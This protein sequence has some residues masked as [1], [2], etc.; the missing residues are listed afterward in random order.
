[1]TLSAETSR[2]VHALIASRLGLDVSERRQAELA[3]SLRLPCPGSPAEAPDAYVARLAAL[4]DHSPAW[5]RLVSRLTVG[6]TYFFRNGAAFDALEREVLPALIATRRSAGIHRLRLWSAGCATG[7]EPFS[8]AMLLDRLL[9]DRAEWAITILATDIN[10][11]ALDVARRGCYRAWS[12]RETPAW[13]R[14]RYFRPRP[15]NT[16][17]VEP[18]IRQMVVFAPL[19]LAEDSYPAPVTNTTAMDLLLC[20]NVLMYFT[21]EAQRRASA[22][23]VRALAPDGWLV[24]SPAEASV[25]RFRPLVP[26]NFPGATFYRQ[27]RK[28]AGAPSPAP[29]PAPVDLWAP[30]AGPGPAE[31]PPGPDLPP[32][33]TPVRD[34]SRR[35]ASIADARAL[36]DQGRLEEAQRLCEAMIARDRL[37]PEPYL[38][39]AAIHQERDDVP[40]ALKV[41]RQAV[42]L[43]PD[44][45]TAHLLRGALLRRC[46]DKRREARRALETAVRL[47]GRLPPDAPVDGAGGVTARRLLGTARAYLELR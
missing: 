14:E 38:L 12:L 8:L 44:A 40:A 10:V 37:D 23:L 33:P 36:A 3:Q 45:A 20:R 46:K 5:R 18:R 21:P 22:R 17:E 47:L 26:V 9:P 34:A 4:P 28:A 13:A 29:P 7:E 16:F 1:M 42:Y 15:G 43:A 27:D 30:G 31:A 19:N 35:P 25:E 2:R 39:L 41:L 11:E 24:V 6:E 32:P